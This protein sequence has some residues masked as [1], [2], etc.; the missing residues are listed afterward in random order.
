[1]EPLEPS[2]KNTFI[3]SL[4]GICFAGIIIADGYYMYEK[5]TAPKKNV[6]IPTEFSTCEIKDI[7][8]VNHD[9]F[10]YKLNA[11]SVIKSIPFHIVLKDDSCQIGRS[12]TPIYVKENEIGLLIKHYPS[13]AISSMLQNVHVGDNL[14][15]RGPVETMSPYYPNSV[16]QLALVFYID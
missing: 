4:L 11:K 15:V 10:L 9:T 14:H 7:V 16:K 1:M 13:G 12:Y 6:L 2:K 5:F 3:N 8:Q